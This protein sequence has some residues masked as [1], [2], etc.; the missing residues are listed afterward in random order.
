MRALEWDGSGCL[1]VIN[2]HFASRIPA[3]SQSVLRVEEILDRAVED[4]GQFEGERQ[5]GVEATTLDR[6]DRLTRD[7]ERVCETL[8]RP[9]V[10]SPLIGQCVLHSQPRAFAMRYRTAVLKNAIAMTP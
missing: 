9:S 1:E 6:D 10:L 8:L 3:P 4:P 2:A 5:R 7:A